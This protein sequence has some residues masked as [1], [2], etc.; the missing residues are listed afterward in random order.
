MHDYPPATRVGLLFALVGVVA[1]LLTFTGSQLAPTTARIAAPILCPQGY[2][3]SSARGWG[4]RNPGGK[5]TAPHIELTCICADG[6]EQKFGSFSVWVG[7]YVMY[8]VPLLLV[9]LL[10]LLVHGLVSP[11]PEE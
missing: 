6:T 5:S 10:F 11:R 3:R 1:A 2:V 9:G 4:T 7:L 8:A